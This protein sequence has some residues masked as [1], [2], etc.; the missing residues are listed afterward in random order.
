MSEMNVYRRSILIVMAA[1][2]LFG[3][4]SRLAAQ[5]FCAPPKPPALPAPPDPQPPVC[6]PKDCEKCCKSPGAIATGAYIL[7]AQDLVIRT[8][9]GFPL[10]VKRHY[11]SSRAIDGPLGIGWS[12]NLNT[13]L[14]YATY[15]AI[16]PSTWYH[17]ADVLMP[18]GIVY[19]FSETTPGT[20]TPPVGR[21]ERL[22]RNAEGSFVL[23][24]E[25]GRSIMT[26]DSQ[27]DLQTMSDEFGNAL[28]FSYS[29]G[30]LQRVADLSGSAR[31]ID[32]TWVNGR[33][34]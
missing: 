20:F 2:A 6:D 14:F 11:D 4:T 22:V 15:L 5:A 23:T 24:L 31:Y 8:A 13:H 25:D 1:T 7:D 33:I 18:T 17:E 16:A 12:S 29:G 3:A 32:L 9:A 27:G 21:R 34:A 19:R 28:Q 10:E 30:K 26:F